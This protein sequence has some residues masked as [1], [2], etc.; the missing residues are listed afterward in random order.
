VS[1]PAPNLAEAL[2][3]PRVEVTRLVDGSGVL[4]DAETLDTLRVNAAG[5]KLVE[6]WTAG[7]TQRGALVAILMGAYDV[8]EETARADVRSFETEVAAFVRRAS[9]PR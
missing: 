4:L 3:G 1:S 9:P 2:L 6:A 5:M 7:V 8:D